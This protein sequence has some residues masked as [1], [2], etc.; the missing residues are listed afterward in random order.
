MI[1]GLIPPSGAYLKF[2]GRGSIPG[3]S[4]VS[5]FLEMERVCP[6]K[7]IAVKNSSGDNVLNAFRRKSKG[8]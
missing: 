8:V 6:S 1:S 7:A 4:R 3:L 5:W 2:P